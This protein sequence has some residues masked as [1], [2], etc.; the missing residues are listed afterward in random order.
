M[1]S[2]GKRRRVVFRNLGQST[3]AVCALLGIMAVFAF[4][5]F[6]VPVAPIAFFIAFIFG[7]ADYVIWMFGIQACV[8]FDEGYAVI[9]N[10]WSVRRI[11]WSELADI[12][13]SNGIAFKLDNGELVRA[14]AYSASLAGS[15]SR[16]SKQ[17]KT[18]ERMREERA[19]Y[20][21]AARTAARPPG[22]KRRFHMPAMPLLALVAVM[23][24]IMG[25]AYL[26]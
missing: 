2:S 8:R 25:V 9:D 23:E 15:V 17:E 14:S 16:R 5:A 10:G 6:T 19:V 3:F 21:S 7:L 12:V 13:V 18:A 4:V 22:S 11:A 26:R 1:T 24:A 20:S